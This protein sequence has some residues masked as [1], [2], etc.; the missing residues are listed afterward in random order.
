MTDETAT[1]L[2]AVLA[3]ATRLRLAITADTTE[4]LERFDFD[5]KG[6]A[7]LL[8]TTTGERYAVFAGWRATSR[9]RLDGY[10]M[11]DGIGRIVGMPARAGLNY[12][13][14]PS[15]SDLWLNVPDA[16]WERAKAMT[17]DLLA[18]QV[19]A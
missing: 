7:Y 10:A 17:R 12:G 6:A 5:G 1:H 16:A 18:L 11:E 14:T 4:S 13:E 8:T 2:P 3:M 19:P 9:T 15:E